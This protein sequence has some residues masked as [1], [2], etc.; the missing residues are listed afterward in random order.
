MHRAIEEYKEDLAQEPN[1][2]ETLE[3][4]GGA[5]VEV[6]M[7]SE[8]TEYL[9]Q[10]IDMNPLKV[11]NHL[12]LAKVLSLQQRYEEAIAVLKKAIVS[13]SNAGNKPAVIELQ[14]Y[15]W[16]IEDTKKNKK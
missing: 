12:V 3:S 7:L 9:H 8:A 2:V 15:L 10:A 16:S 11:E 1:S 5:M 4:V 14:R 6:G 13:F